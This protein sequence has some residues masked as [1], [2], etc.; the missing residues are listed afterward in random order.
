MINK[1][2][3][4]YLPTRASYQVRKPDFKETMKRHFIRNPIACYVARAIPVLIVLIA[5]IVG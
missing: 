1:K 5:G 4:V 2:R 3:T